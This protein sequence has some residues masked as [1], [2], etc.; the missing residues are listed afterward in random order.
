[1]KVTNPATVT[2]VLHLGLTSPLSK[3]K[4]TAE[5]SIAAVPK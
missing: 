4:N 2:E 3:K 1:M 5:Q